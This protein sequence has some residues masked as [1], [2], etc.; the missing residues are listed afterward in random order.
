MAFKNLEAKTY[1]GRASGD[2][3]FKFGGKNTT[4]ETDMRVDG[5]GMPY[6]LAEFQQ[7][8]PKITGM[9][10]ANLSLAGDIK[11]NANPLA[12]IHGSGHITI[13]KGE[14]PSVARNRNMIEMERFRP[15]GTAT[16]AASAFSTF[17]GD[18]ELRSQRLYS[19]RI[20]VNFYGV[21]VDGAGSTSVVKGGS[22]DYR[23]VA[24]V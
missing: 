13:L 15:P 20:G 17:S 19:K 2:F 14:L 7:G 18:M 9:M 6:L 3:S 12:D 21:N 22:M 23:G 24:T 1:R 8:P 4:F 11:H 16:L 5:V 10:R